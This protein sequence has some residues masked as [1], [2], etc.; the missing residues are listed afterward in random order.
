MAGDEI[1]KEA[2]AH[3]VYLWQVAKAADI[4]EATLMRWLRDDL[5]DRRAEILKNAVLAAARK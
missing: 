5:D 4:S 1:R 3:G 2:K